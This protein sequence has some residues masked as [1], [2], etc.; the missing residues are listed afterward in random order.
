MGTTIS[1]N[2][3][4]NG[5]VN[6]IKLADNIAIKNP[7]LT[8]GTLRTPST[9]LSILDSTGT[10]KG[11]AI[12]KLLVSTAY[13]AD[14]G[15]IPIKSGSAYFS[16]DIVINGDLTVKGDTITINSETVNIAD[17]IIQLNS[18]MP[19]DA[20]PASDQDAGIEVNRGSLPYAKIIWDEGNRYWTLNQVNDVNKTSA[21]YRIVDLNLA[22]SSYVK[23]SGSTMTDTLKINKSSSSKF[24]EMYSAGLTN[25]VRIGHSSSIFSFDLRYTG[26]ETG[27]LKSLE[28]WTDNT[29]ND[30]TVGVPL[31]VF[32]IQQDGIFKITK[33]LDV[34]GNI[35]VSGTV[36]GVD[37]ASHAADTTT[38]KK[39]VT[40]AYLAALAGTNGVPS[41][42]N[43]YVTNSDSRLSNSRTPTSHGDTLHSALSY[44][45]IISDG[46][47]QRTATTAKQSIKITGTNNTTVTVSN[48][49]TYDAIVTIDSQHNHDATYL[50]LANPTEQVVA[51]HIKIDGNLYVTGTTTYVNTE[52]MSV[53]NSSII[54]NSDL[55]D[56]A[57]PTEDSGI[58]IERGKLNNSII[59][60]NESDHYWEFAE[61]NVTTTLVENRT[62]IIDQTY[63]DL[64]YLKLADGGTIAN[65]ITI[66]AV[67]RTADSYVRVLASDSNKA[68]FEA[69]GNS[70]G[71]GYI[72]V[73]QDAAYGGGI[74][75]NGDN[76]PAF[77]NGEVMD[78]VTFFRR[79]AGT[80]T[81]VMSYF[82][83]SSAVYFAGNIVLSTADATVDGVDVSVL[84]TNY[85]NHA[86][87]IV[88]HITAA[89]RTAWNGKQAALGYT[90]LSTAGGTM[91]GNI[92]FSDDG[93]GV[94]WSRNTDSAS[95]KF[96]NTGDADTDSRLEFNIGDNGNE[97]FRWTG[98]AA[99]VTT[100]LMKL[101]P[102]DTTNGLTF[103]GNT[104]WH[105]GNFNPA[106]VDNYGGWSFKVNGT[107]YEKIG[108]DGTLNFKAGSNITLTKSAANEITITGGQ[109]YAGWNL[110]V[111]GANQTTIASGN[112]VNFIGAGGT[113]I[114]K[115]GNNV[116]ITSSNTNQSNHLITFSGAEVTKTLT[117]NFGVA[118]NLYIICIGSNG[119]Q[120]HV[121]YKNKTTNTVDICI[122]DKM[123]AGETLEV[124]VSIQK[125]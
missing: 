60:W 104:V 1:T 62:R 64:R 67:D 59:Q 85:T 111:N 93:E 16:G 96:Y 118:A 47:N 54:L 66:G 5:A 56:D 30:G 6:G 41:S 57:D 20:V 72:Y 73:G 9:Y 49:A 86:G 36:D 91:T 10:T 50:K 68:G 78:R 38:N 89:E 48:D 17:N 27:V 13:S 83:N 3:I 45:D 33:E 95:I 69:Y 102:A 34:T 100:E 14:W 123:Y 84:S 51:S 98:T 42:T 61:R 112:T 32:R 4:R 22:D 77:A 120:R 99:S 113:T 35:I 25:S 87:D 94:V 19:V 115:S 65:N 8:T 124:S 23:L 81:A 108:P 28:L 26:S 15:K 11:L 106:N 70:Q 21:F 29:N 101:T 121:Y 2:D 39:H 31:K 97:F 125:I 109:G 12:D 119:P 40:D 37:I 82:H 71:T 76:N 24:I 55:A 18:N 116:T 52:E 92:T 107:Q 90:P 58:E 122:D 53:T 110:Q 79:T 80:T 74:S 63:G 75:Y 103:R 7:D 117:H 44:F 43:K 114:T 88:G 46:T 105:A